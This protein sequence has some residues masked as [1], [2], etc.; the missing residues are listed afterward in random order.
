MRLGSLLRMQLLALALLSIVFAAC[1]PSLMAQSA[2]TSALSGVVTDPSGAAIPNA[3]VTIAS[4][5]T[6][7]SRTASTGADGSYR[8]TLLPPGNYRLSFAAPGFKT[9]EVSSQTLN[10]TETVELN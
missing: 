1:M 9:S 6:G 7:Q 2:G 10:V 8:F 4:N 3:T 5:A